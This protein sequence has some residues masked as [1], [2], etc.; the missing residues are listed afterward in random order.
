MNPILRNF[1]YFS[2]RLLNKGLTLNDYQTSI[3]L[4]ESTDTAGVRVCVVY[5][6]VCVCVCVFVCRG[7]SN[8]HRIRGP[9]MRNST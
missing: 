2:E 7:G 6:C 1:S 3:N 4:A 5:V 8:F 9:I